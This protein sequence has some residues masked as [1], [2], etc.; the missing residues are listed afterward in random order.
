MPLSPAA[1]FKVLTY[2]ALPI[3]GKHQWDVV[4]SKLNTYFVIVSLSNH[5][6]DNQ[7]FNLL[8]YDR[9]Q[10]FIIGLEM[11]YN[12]VIFFVKLTFFI[13]YFDLFRVSRRI[14]IF[15]YIGIASIFTVYAGTTI[16]Y[17]VSCFPTPG[18]TWLEAMSDPRC[19]APSQNVTYI[20]GSFGVISDFYILSL[21][22]PLILRMQLPRKEKIG[23]CAL[24][25]TGFL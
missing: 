14:R 5:R 13:L 11:G 20:V 19:V 24:F 10:L 22:I 16:V 18:K 15:V 23:V 2:A 25:M 7:D 9:M 3:I 1:L 8:I 12:I 6:L 4:A 17:G 21:P